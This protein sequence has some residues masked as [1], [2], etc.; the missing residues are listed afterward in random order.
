MVS[1]RCRCWCIWDDTANQWASRSAYVLP[2]TMPQV[3][4]GA[5]ASSSP[6]QA[7]PERVF[8]AARKSKSRSLDQRAVISTR[9]ARVIR[10][11]RRDRSCS[12][13]CP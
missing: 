4:P 6:S 7:D 3:P 1:V 11:A 13:R 2:P 8:M 5:L 10:R 9:T 12:G